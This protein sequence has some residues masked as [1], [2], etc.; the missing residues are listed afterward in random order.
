MESET[1][2]HSILYTII[3]VIYFIIAT[4]KTCYFETYII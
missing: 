3:I 2:K 4:L 1:K